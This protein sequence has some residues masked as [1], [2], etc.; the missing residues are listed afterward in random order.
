M[1]KLLTLAILF[2]SL[3]LYSQKTSVVTSDI[4]NFWVAFDKI[5]STQDMLQQQD[6]LKTFFLDKGTPGLKAIMEAR[7]YT[8]QHYIDA[9]N[10]YPKFWKSVRGNTLK[11]KIYG[12]ELDKAIV[13]LKKVYPDLKRTTV[14]FTIGA[15]RTGGTAYNGVV[16]IGSEVAMTDESTVSTEFPLDIAAGRRAY[17]NQNPIRDI[18]LLNVHEYV[19][20][21]QKPLVQN[22]LSQVVYEG[23]AEFVSTKALQKPSA[24]PAVHFGF[25]NK[26]IK[27]RFEEEMFNFRVQDKWLWSDTENEFGMRD[28]GYYIGYALCE[29]YYNQ[30]TDKKAAIKKMIE[31][32]YSNEEEIE[33]FVDG[34]KFFSAP[35]SQLYSKYEASRPTVVKIIGVENNSKAVKPGVTKITVTF[36]EAMNTYFRNFDYGPLGEDYVLAIQKVIGFSKDGR[37]ITFEVNLQPGRHYQMT[38]SN[39]FRNIKGALL[40]PYLIDIQTTK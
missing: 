7:G 2:I 3:F 15:L 33:R 17:F 18:V 32:D 27:Q 19:H 29:K 36:S 9:I 8:A 28:L 31:L 38:V 39:G 37:S 34:T 4:D 35:L 25:K 12:R 23:V 22:L 11:A 20:T 24:T 21:Q 6:Y 26:D 30:A 1:Q 16:L 5:T 13:K 14:Y 10:A 40:K